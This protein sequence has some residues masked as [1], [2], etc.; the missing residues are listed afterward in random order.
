MSRLKPTRRAVLAA[1]AFAGL[2]GFNRAETGLVPFTYLLP[3]PREAIA[4][5]PFT[6]AESLGW[7]RDAGLDVSFEVRRGGMEVGKALARGEGDLGGAS[8]DTPV[9]LR[10]QGFAVKGTALLGG[11]AFLTIITRRDRRVRLADLSGKVIGVPSRTDVSTYGMEHVIAN[12]GAKDV[13]LRAAPAS[14]LWTGLGSGEFDGIVGTVDWGVR[15]ERSGVAL[16]YLPLDTVFPGAMAQAVLASEATILAHP[17]RLRAFNQA[18]I[19][20]I[21]LMLDR[22]QDASRQY[23]LATPATDLSPEEVTRIFILF[24]SEVYGR[25]PDIGEADPLRLEAISGEYRRRGL[26][27]TNLS[28]ADAFEAGLSG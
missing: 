19:R 16:D 27:S 2:T 5:A 17:D 8:G 1:G 7:Y 15:A 6:L 26:M 14:D 9:L 21:R 22:P 4:L 28:V 12:T 13:T 10:D 23:L 18:T 20:A 25:G 24:G 11:H 3:A